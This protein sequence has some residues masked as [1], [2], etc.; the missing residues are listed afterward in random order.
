M[1]DRTFGNFLKFITY[2]LIAGALNKFLD[3]YSDYLLEISFR[4]TMLTNITAYSFVVISLAAICGFIGKSAAVLDPE[5]TIGSG[6]KKQFI[7]FIGCLFLGIS[8]CLNIQDNGR[9]L[10]GIIV[11]VGAAAS[12]YAVSY[13]NSFSRIEIPRWSNVPKALYRHENNCYNLALG[14]IC[15]TGGFIGIGSATGILSV[16]TTV[17][18]S[19]YAIF[20]SVYLSISR[21]LP[22]NTMTPSDVGVFFNVS[23][24]GAAAPAA[25]AFTSAYNHA[26]LRQTVS[27]FALSGMIVLIVV[28]NLYFRYHKREMPSSNKH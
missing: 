9:H 16:D 17:Y 23:V 27:L 12:T 28:V 13:Y 4:S 10:E 26:P 21:L 19:V 1:T 25:A 8:V 22:K 14:C 7:H 24:V 18:Y 20:L 6:L 2:V 15:I 3:V 5:E 11:L